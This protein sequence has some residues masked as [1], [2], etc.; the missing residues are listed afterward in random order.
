[1][2]KNNKYTILGISWLVFIT[3]L[4]LFSFSTDID[5]GVEIPHLDKMVHFTFYFGVVVLGCLSLLEKG[6]QDLNRIIKQLI[7]FAIAYGLLI[8]FLQYVM[9]YQRE[10]DILDFLANSLGAIV[11]G[12][13]IKKYR[14]L[15][16]RIK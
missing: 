12:L 6:G 2:L 11:A 14:S 5:T 16:Y 1:M 8:E 9:P 13:L 4:S 10:A 15:I 7:I 3:S